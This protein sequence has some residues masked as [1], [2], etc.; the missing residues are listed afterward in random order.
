MKILLVSP[1]PPPVGGIATVTANLIDFLKSGPAKVDLVLCNTTI[2][3]RS[4]T[5]QSLIVRIYTGFYNSIK[6]FF[7]VKRT[8][9]LEMPD[10]IHLASSSSFAL[11]KDYLIIL[12]AKHNK[13]PIVIHWHFGRI[14]SLA[15]QRNWEWKLLSFVIKRSTLSIVIDSKS[16]KTLIN[17][18]LIN[19][20]NIPNPLGLEIEQKSRALIGKSNQRKQGRL[21][22]VGHIVRGKGVFELVEA[23]SELPLVKEL[24]LIGPCE[25]KVKKELRAI[26]GRRENGVWL[27]LVGELNQDQ[28]VEHMIISPILV[29]PS[30]TEGFPNS[31]LE[32]MAMGCA[33]I[34][35]DVGAI[36]EMLD[37]QSNNPCGIRIPPKNIAKLKEALLEMLQ[38]PS[39]TEMMSKNGILRVLNNYT[40]ENITKRYIAEWE[41]VITRYS[42]TTTK[43]NKVEYA[44]NTPSKFNVRKAHGLYNHNLKIILVSPLPPPVGG[45]ASWTPNIINYF[46]NGESKIELTLLNSALKGKSITSNSLVKRFYSGIYNSLWINIEFRK[47]LKNNKP[48]LIHLV[49]SSSLALFKDYL[50]VTLAKKLKIPVILHWRFGRI[51][52]LA[53]QG[54]W[55]WKLLNVVIKTSTLS[56]V[57]DSKS[58]NTLSNAGF[59]NIVNIP[60]PLG[61]DIEQKS[62][63]LFGKFNQ[64]Q[65]D[66]L[67]FVG[68]I[69]RSKGVYELIEACSQLPLIKK[70]LLIGP[71]EENVKKDLRAIARKRE[72]GVWLNLVGELSKDQVLEHMFISP[73]L[74]LPSYTEGFPNA[75]LEGMAMGCAVIATDVGAIPEMLDIQSI[76][77]CGICIPPHNVEKLKEA[78]L[79]LVIDPSK[80]EAMGKNG[81][82]RVLNN[83]TFERI[84]EKY[85]TVWENA[86][87]KGPIKMDQDI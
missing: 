81:M 87:N 38:D 16:Y 62:R 79:E 17:K 55:E 84:A 25:E 75:V 15:A 1:L 64:R 3:F 57:I 40:I 71:C 21:I 66:Q 85:K 12:T 73:V 50:L 44:Q 70:L 43:G 56:I 24:L 34:A 33:V 6:T 78:I 77:P 13:I 19:A 27:N 47:L 61:L 26:A 8:T 29:L 42:T 67:I 45:I 65:Q 82:E 51:P 59:T 20:V 53:A 41:N 11:F 58:Y 76:N 48:S 31:V 46:A 74:V 30:Y 5:S 9:K 22:F 86:S 54:N 35:T 69:L 4:I 49:S 60:N 32:G 7:D 68:H 72:N 10:L 80:I 39:K 23:C 2:K 14:P 52:S 63:A 36:P 83:Y 37:V 28:V 18:G